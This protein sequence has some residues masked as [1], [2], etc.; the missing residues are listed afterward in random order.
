MPKWGRPVK[1]VIS[2]CANR[3]TAIQQKTL[4]HLRAGARL[5]WIVDPVARTVTVYR[6]D[7]SARVL[8]ESDTLEGE[9][10]LR[11]FTLPLSEI[12]G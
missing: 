12:F 7:G 5:V 1:Q 10:V 4:D 11:D 8:Q 6:P 3:Q 9:D 2:G